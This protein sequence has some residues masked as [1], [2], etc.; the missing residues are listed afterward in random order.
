M[1]LWDW[2]QDNVSDSDMKARLIGVRTKMPTFS[3]FYG[4]QLAI[5]VLAHSD[6]L[7]TSLQRVEL[8]AVDAQNNANL[9]VTVLRGTIRLGCKPSFDQGQEAAVKLEF[10]APS[11]QC[12]HKMPSRYFEC[13][14]VKIEVCKAH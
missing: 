10:Q 12:R 5:L 8:G 4:V 6:N 11:L 9:S 13:I 3:I 7:S 14:T 1:K 2:S